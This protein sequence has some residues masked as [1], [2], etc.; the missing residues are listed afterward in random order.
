VR[1]QLRAER[2]T[3]RRLLAAPGAVPAPP[4]LTDPTDAEIAAVR[5]TSPVIGDYW[6]VA[7]D[8]E[9]TPDIL[10]TGLPV[11]RF[12]EVPLLRGL[13][14]PDLVAIAAVKRVFPTSKVMQ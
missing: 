12:A 5:L 6:L 11:F 8:D 7:D 9:M 1:D 2:D 14:A 4:P 10:A 3:L 13:T